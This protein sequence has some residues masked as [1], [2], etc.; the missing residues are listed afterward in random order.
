MLLELQVARI[1]RRALLWLPQA[2]QRHRVAPLVPRGLTLLLVP[3]RVPVALR[4][5]IKPVVVR[6]VVPRVLRGGIRPR[7]ELLLRPVVRRV[8]RVLTPPLQLVPTPVV[9]P[10]T[11]KL[12]QDQRAAAPAR[13]LSEILIVF[14]KEC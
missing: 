10:V 7:R 5:P 14:L 2:Q 12:R 8:R 11:T 6:L 3:T 9:P 4:E 1:A 13:S